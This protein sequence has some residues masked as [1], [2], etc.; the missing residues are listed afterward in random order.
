M[1]IHPLKMDMASWVRGKVWWVEGGGV[2]GGGEKGG[3]GE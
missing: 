2:V 3:V 1:Y